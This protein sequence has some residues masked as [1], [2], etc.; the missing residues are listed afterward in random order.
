MRDIPHNGN[1]CA[2][3]RAIIAL[4]DSLQIEVVAEGI[5]DQEQV[6]F[7]LRYHCALGQ[8]WLYGEALDGEQMVRWHQGKTLA[9]S[10]A[11]H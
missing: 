7:L 1:D 10:T 6:D 3:T 11:A 5:E 4:A 9:G 8:G 2:I